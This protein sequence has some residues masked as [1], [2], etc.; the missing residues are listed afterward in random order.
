VV[1][2]LFAAQPLSLDGRSWCY[3]FVG[4]APYRG[5]FERERAQAAAARLE[6][7]GYETFV[8]GVAAYSTLGWFDD[9]LMSSFIDWPDAELAA[10]LIHELAHRRVWVAGDV[11]FNESY[12]TFVA[13]EGA[14][15][16][17]D[18]RG[19]PEVG[20]G[21]LDQRQARAR[22]QDLLLAARAE[23]AR[24]Y[25]SDAP[26]PDRMAAREHVFGALRTCYVDRLERYGG[27]VFDRMMAAVN[28]AFLVS[29]ST[30]H[31]HVG[32]FRVMFADTGGDWR[33]FHERVAQLASEPESGRAARLEALAER[34]VANG[35]DQQNA[36]QVECEALARHGLRGEAA[37]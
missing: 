25:T 7:A 13:D 1:W 18:A 4:C 19:G 23:L 20:T 37:G 30:Y 17:F 32:A 34:Q 15:L 26:Q 24:V 31:D 33:Q 22:W 9:S 21:Y 12:A 27:G 6:A 2:N 10:L 36:D 3:P 28:N 5:Y 16:W 14:A 8:G 11:P 29:L 35:R